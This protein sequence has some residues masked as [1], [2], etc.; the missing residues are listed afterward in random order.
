MKNE[1]K[2]NRLNFSSKV[3]DNFIDKRIHFI[4]LFGFKKDDFV[5]VVIN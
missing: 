5:N 4:P 2:Q 3:G 1:E